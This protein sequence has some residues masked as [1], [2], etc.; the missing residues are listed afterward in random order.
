VERRS[1]IRSLGTRKVVEKAGALGQPR[2]GPPGV[3]GSSRSEVKRTLL[4]NYT[5]FLTS[6]KENWVTTKINWTY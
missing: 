1:N 5:I 6:R 3:R 4:W 2:L